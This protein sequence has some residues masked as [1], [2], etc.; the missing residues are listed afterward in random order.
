MADLCGIDKG[1][2]V[3]QYEV[4]GVVTLLAEALKTKMRNENFAVERTGDGGMVVTTAPMGTLAFLLAQT[5]VDG[6]LHA[7]KQFKD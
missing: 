3:A 4:F 1:A 6:W 2:R 7:Y 5:F